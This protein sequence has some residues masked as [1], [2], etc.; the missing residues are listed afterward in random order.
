MK[1]DILYIIIV[2]AV[3]TVYYTYRNFNKKKLYSWIRSIPCIKRTINTKLS[4]QLHKIKKGFVEDRFKHVDMGHTELP[5]G[6]MSEAD[7]ISKIDDIC[8]YYKEESKISGTVYT[9]MYRWK[10]IIAEIYGKT[11]WLNP[12]HTDIWPR[13]IQLEAETCHMCC[14]L[15]HLDKSCAVFTTGGT[16]SNTQAVYAHRE[17]YR[18][19]KG[20]TSPNIVAPITAHT[21]FKKA[22]QILNVEYRMCQVNPLTNKAA[23]WDMKRLIDSNTILLVASCPSFPYGIVDPVREIGELALRYDIGLHLD[24]CLGGFMVPFTELSEMCDFRTPGVTSISADLHKFGE[25]PKGISILMF[26]NQIIKKYLTFVDLGWTGGFYAVPSFLGSRS[27][28][29]PA[30][31]WAMMNMIGYH[32]YKDTT[33]RLIELRQEICC[34]I[35]DT[36]DKNDLC[37]YGSPELSIFGLKSNNHNIHYINKILSEHG[38]EFNPL[39]SGIHFCL[40]KRHLNVEN[41]LKDMVGDL[42]HAIIYVKANPDE[43]HGSL[44]TIYCTTQQLPEYISDYVLEEMGRV[45]ME[46]KS[47]SRPPE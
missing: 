31:T 13:L 11:A 7:V 30:I 39:P 10:N 4:K 41:F 38:W 46:V 19:E 5:D 15:F 27:G 17:K 8:Q 22:C 35:N 1:V 33:D 9:D 40:T 43:D 20:I 36:F 12:T 42:M 2:L 37:V 44:A 26:R 14:N 29:T 24:C 32:G 47:M 23:V 3:Y 25:T 21:S 6:S 34:V 28:S 45:Y 16:M 18:E